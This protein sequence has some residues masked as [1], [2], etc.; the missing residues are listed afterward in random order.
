M[1]VRINQ[2]LRRPAR[3]LGRRGMIVAGW[4]AAATPVL[5][6]ALLDI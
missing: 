2:A 5:M 3:T 4:L 6:P 1:I